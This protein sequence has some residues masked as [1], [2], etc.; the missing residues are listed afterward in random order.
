MSKPS[1]SR[2]LSFPKECGFRLFTMPENF[3]CTRGRAQKSLRACVK[4]KNVLTFVA[5]K[6]V[7]HIIRRVRRRVVRTK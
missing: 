2:A 7:S 1:G 6:K 5:M 3:L 4:V